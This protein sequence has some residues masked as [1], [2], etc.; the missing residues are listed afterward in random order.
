VGILASPSSSLNPRP[1]T[2][3]E[4]VL[5]CNQQSLP[6]LALVDS[7]ADENFLDIDIAAQAGIPCEVLDS[8]LNANAL[9][10]Q[11]L[12]QV[13]HRTKPVNLILSGNHCEFIQFHLISSPHAPIVLGHPWLRTHNPQIDWVTGKIISWSFFCLSSCLQSALPPAEAAA[14]P[15]KIEP[16]DLLSVPMEYHSLGEVFSKQR[17]LSLPPHRPYDCPIDLLPGAPLPSSRL[18][19]L[20]R[21][22]RKSMESYIHDSLAAGVIRPSSSPV[23]AGFFFVSKKDR[24]LRPC[25]DYRGL[26]AITIKNKYPLPLIN[27]AFEPLQEATIFSKLDLCNAYHLIRIREGDEWKTAFNTPLGHFEYW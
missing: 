18:F 5:C 27:S 22:E 24:S 15:P 17:A 21:P 10:G 6:L 25:I 12:A 4:A 26:N 3:L 14:P 20:S 7:G 19:N 2:Q 23:G 16:S 11:F 9:N 13:T 8:P 1:R